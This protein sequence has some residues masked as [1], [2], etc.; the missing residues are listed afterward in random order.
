[1]VYNTREKQ[2]DRKLERVSIERKGMV[3]ERKRERE[4]EFGK[5]ER[6]T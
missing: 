2:K 1:M 3:V 5:R 4:T 6:K